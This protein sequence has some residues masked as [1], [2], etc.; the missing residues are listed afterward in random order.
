MVLCSR[1][2]DT[3]AMGLQCV[4]NTSAIWTQNH[5]DGAKSFGVNEL[6]GVSPD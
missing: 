1:G 5:G 2:A 3:D 4:C 6:A